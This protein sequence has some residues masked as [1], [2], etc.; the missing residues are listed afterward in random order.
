MATAQQFDVAGNYAEAV[1]LYEKARH[2]DSLVEPVATRRLAILYDKQGQFDKARSE[3]EKLLQKN[4]RDADT[5]NNLGYGYY[6]RGQWDLAEQHLRKALA[7][8]PQ[9]EHAWINLGMTLGQ[10]QRYDE[11]LNAFAKVVDRAEGLCNLAFIL[12]TQGK[13]EEAKQAY[14]EALRLNPGLQL[15]Q[16]ALAK[17]HQSTAVDTVEDLTKHPNRT[18][19]EGAS[20]VT[21]SRV[22]DFDSP[23][24]VDPDAVGAWKSQHVQ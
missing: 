10:Q 2:T 8:N 6:A 14:T 4:P 1:T 20:G 3:Y 23:I 11:S 15:A 9:H 19:S 21:M 5:L 13:R 16:G 24:F 18:D 17:L 7:A 12:T 22:T